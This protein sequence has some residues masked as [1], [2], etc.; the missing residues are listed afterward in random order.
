MISDWLERIMPNI[1]LKTFMW[2]QLQDNSSFSSDQVLATLVSRLTN[3]KILWEDGMGCTRQGEACL[4]PEVAER[5]K[6]LKGLENVNILD[7]IKM[8]LED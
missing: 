3:I 7:V 6:L 8:P 4:L 5:G 2:L 1:F